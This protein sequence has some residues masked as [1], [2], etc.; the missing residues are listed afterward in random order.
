MTVTTQQMTAEAHRHSGEYR[1]LQ[2]ACFAEDVRG[3]I[4]LAD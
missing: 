2:S 3:P 1:R 4:N